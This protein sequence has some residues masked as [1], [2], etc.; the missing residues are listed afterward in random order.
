MH[1]SAPGL[2][3]ADCPAA[4]SRPS[5]EKDAEFGPGGVAVS[6]NGLVMATAV[7]NGTTAVAAVQ[8]VTTAYIVA[9]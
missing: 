6:G 4:W 8:Y 2:A 1:E 5:L 7:D 9:Q 3:E